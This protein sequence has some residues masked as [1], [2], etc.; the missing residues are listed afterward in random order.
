MKEYEDALNDFYVSAK[1][2]PTYEQMVDMYRREP[3]TCKLDFIDKIDDV[4]EKLETFTYH[5]ALLEIQIRNKR[6]PCMNKNLVHKWLDGFIDLNIEVVNYFRERMVVGQ[7][8][9]FDDLHNLLAGFVDE[10]GLKRTPR[11]TFLQGFI[12]LK[13]TTKYDRINNH[14]YS[15]YRLVG[16]ADSLTLKRIFH[17]DEYKFIDLELK[18]NILTKKENGNGNENR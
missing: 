10:Y 13:R 4:L 17:K 2:L 11:I 8:Y 18:K 7:I 14:R 5:S 3:E 1:C 9:T 6:K 12:T 15:G 16:F